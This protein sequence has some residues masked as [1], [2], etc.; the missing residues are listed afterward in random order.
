MKEFKIG[1]F[2]Q[3]AY[4]GGQR[5]HAPAP[6]RWNARSARVLCRL[7]ACTTML[8]DIASS[9]GAGVPKPLLASQ[10][11]LLLALLAAPLAKRD[12]GLACPQLQAD[13]DDEDEHGRQ[14]V[15]SSFVAFPCQWYERS[16]CYSD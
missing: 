5:S 6:P 15:K 7:E 14:P 16:Q 2:Q 11:H 8:A 10:A 13:Y 4:A 12:N 9:R 3:E 1:F